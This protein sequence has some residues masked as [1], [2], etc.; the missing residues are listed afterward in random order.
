V[1]QPPRGGDERAKLIW[2]GCRSNG[3]PLRNS[4]VPVTECQDGSFCCGN[5]NTKCCSAG[6][7]SFVVNGQV[8]ISKPS[9]TSSTTSSTSTA[10]STSSVVVAM[11]SKSSSNTGAIAGGVVGGVVGLVLIL[12]AIWFFVRR[13]K[14]VGAD[15]GAKERLALHEMESTD[16]QRHEMMG[17]GSF[18]TGNKKM[19]QSGATTG[20]G[21]VEVPGTH[22]LDAGVR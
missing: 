4:H 7:G 16:A 21:M 20:P 2:G 19:G 22:E 18:A 17:S 5:N 3:T 1:S 13:R 12:G 14:S 8:T 15:T 10:T 11:T 9:S 6:Q